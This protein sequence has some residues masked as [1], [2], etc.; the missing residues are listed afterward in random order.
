[1]CHSTGRGE[2]GQGRLDYKE[3]VSVSAVGTPSI[4]SS[5]A[6][7]HPYEF[8]YNNLQEYDAQELLNVSFGTPEQALTNVLNVLSQWAAYQAKGYASTSSAPAIINTLA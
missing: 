1:M 3:G 4:L 2:A 7:Q 5:F 6:A 8:A